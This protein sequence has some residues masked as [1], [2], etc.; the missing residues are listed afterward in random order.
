MVG[1]SVVWVIRG[2]GLMWFGSNVVGCSVVGC[3]VVGCS[4]GDP[5]VGGNLT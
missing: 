2:L 4:V 1:C 3:S 5:A